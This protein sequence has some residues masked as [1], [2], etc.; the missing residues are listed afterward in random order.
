MSLSQEGEKTN[1][2]VPLLLNFRP[3]LKSLQKATRHRIGSATKEEPRCQSAK[4]RY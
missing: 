2:I 3:N 1:G 4:V